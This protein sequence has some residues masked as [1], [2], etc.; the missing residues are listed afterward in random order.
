MTIIVVFVVLWVIL[1]LLGS[2][3][4]HVPQPFR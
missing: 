3:G 1:V 4:V 2:A